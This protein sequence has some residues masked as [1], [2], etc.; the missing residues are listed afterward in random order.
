[1]PENGR[2]GI[3]ARKVAASK[4]VSLAGTAAKPLPT[5]SKTT[6]DWECFHGEIVLC[7]PKEY[8]EYRGEI[9]CNYI[10]DSHGGLTPIE[11][12]FEPPAKKAR[13]GTG[14]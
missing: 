7:N 4:Y 8:L 11:C 2:A 12:T 9:R 3:F 6:P 10:P 1:V 5:S 13:L 14:E